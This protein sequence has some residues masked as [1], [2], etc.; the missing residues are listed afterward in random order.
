MKQVRKT[1]LLTGLLVITVSA[2]MAQRDTTKPKA[3]DITSSFRPV[4]RESAKINFNASPPTADTTKPRLQYDIPNPSL[5]LAYQPSSLKPLALQIDSLGKFISSNYIKAGFGSLRTPFVQTGFSFGD[6]NTAGINIFAK[7]VASEGKRDFQ[8]FSS[9]QVKLSGFYKAAQNMEWDASLGMKSDKTYKY[10]YLPESLSF[11]NDSI[12]VR[13]QTISARVGAHNINK[14]EFGLTYSPEVKIDVF[15]DNFK[16]NESNTVVNLPLEKT[17]G[18]NFAA[19]LGVTFDLTRLSLK[20]QSAINNTMWY[21]SPSVIYKTST[22]RL[23]GGI[24]PSWDNKEFKMFPNILAEIGT[25]DKRF[26]LQAGWTGYVRKTT[27]QYLASQNPWLWAPNSLLNTWIEERYAGFKGAIT[28]HFTYSA[29]VAFNKLTNQPL[30]INDTSALGDGKSFQVVNA[31]RINNLNMG[32]ELGYTIEEKFSLITSLQVNN[33]TGIKGQKK[34]WGLMPLEFNTALRLQIIKDLWL[35]SD[36]FVFGGSRY[37]KKNGDVG[38][39]NGAIDLNAGLEF[40]ITKN[41]NLWSQFNNLTNKQYQRWNQ[42][43]VYGFNFV[44]GIIFNFDQKN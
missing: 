43:P 6:G 27:Y 2:V 33:F 40:R 42:Y 25:D 16:N 20:K 3:V 30:F 17:I 5:G 29:K 8:D 36:L 18:N 34:A 14:T 1:I 26:T 24:R 32:G 11:P 15:T 9:T 12:R 22:L 38:K 19:N 28:E 7:H 37:L 10:G 39:L 13:F 21:I 23:Q 41:I 4:L 31:T 35:K 44:G